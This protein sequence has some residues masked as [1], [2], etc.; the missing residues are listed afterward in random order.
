MDRLQNQRPPNTAERRE[1]SAPAHPRQPHVEVSS[2]MTEA[3]V[4]EAPTMEGSATRAQ[5]G[6]AAHGTRPA[7]RR[8]ALLAALGSRAALQQ[9]LLL[10]EVLGPPKALQPP[11]DPGTP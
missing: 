2:R 5:P 11:N 6:P 3:T 4:G 7:T 9:A 1:G 8:Q 10:R